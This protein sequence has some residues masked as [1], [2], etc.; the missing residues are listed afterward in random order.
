MNIDNLYLTEEQKNAV[1]KL[2]SAIRAC[3][4]AKVAF[5]NRYGHVNA[6]NGKYFGKDTFRDSNKEKVFI[7]DIE[8][9]FSMSIESN[10]DLFIATADDQHDMY[11]TIKNKSVMDVLKNEGYISEE[12]NHGRF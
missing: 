2:N 4:K 11:V 12:G 7:P 10:D 9:E 8:D 1:H 5:T 6:F 3:V